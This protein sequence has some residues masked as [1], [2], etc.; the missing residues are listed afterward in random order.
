VILKQPLQDRDSSGNGHIGQTDEPRV[1]SA[2]KKQ[3]LAE[4]LVHRDQDTV[5]TSGP[6]QDDTV[7]GVR[8]ALSAFN[9]VVTEGT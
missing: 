9:D 7:A 1:R 3:K 8:T 2:L 4:V 6:S 5:F